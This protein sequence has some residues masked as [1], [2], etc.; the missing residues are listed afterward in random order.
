MNKKITRYAFID[1]QN[2]NMGVGSDVKFKNKIIYRGWKLDFKKFRVFLKDK[3]KV[4]EAFYLSVI[5]QVKKICMHF[6]RDVVIYWF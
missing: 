3:F 2:L 6:Y 4:E 5:Y 1:S